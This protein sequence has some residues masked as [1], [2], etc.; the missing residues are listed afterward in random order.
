MASYCATALLNSKCWIMRVFERG[1]CLWKRGSFPT[2][3]RIEILHADMS[4]LELG[5][6]ALRDLWRMRWQS[7]SPGTGDRCHRRL[8][9]SQCSKP[10][11]HSG[12]HRWIQSWME[13]SGQLCWWRQSRAWA[14][15]WLPPCCGGSSS[16]RRPAGHRWTVSGWTWPQDNWSGYKSAKIFV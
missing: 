2:I 14:G 5:S 16:R 10:S 12:G 6:S 15:I 4:H 11:Q 1:G 3:H 9:W 7:S 8:L 13:R